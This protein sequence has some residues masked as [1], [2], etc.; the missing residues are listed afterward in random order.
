[1][2]LI[3]Q[4]REDGTYATIEVGGDRFYTVE[5]LCQK[6]KISPVTV[7]SYIRTGKL[8]PSANKI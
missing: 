4:F 2:V 8:P 6:F 7:Y 3:N 1:M 5:E